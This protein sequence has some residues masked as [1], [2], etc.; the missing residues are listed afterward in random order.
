[1]SADLVQLQNDGLLALDFYSR[2]FTSPIKPFIRTDKI[3]NC[4][5]C[6]Y[7]LVAFEEQKRVSDNRKVKRIAQ[8][9]IFEYMCMSY[10]FNKF[11]NNQGFKADIP[12]W[13]KALYITSPSVQPYFS[14][15]YQTTKFINDNTALYDIDFSSFCDT[16][17]DALVLLGDQVTRKSPFQNIKG[18]DIKVTSG[19]TIYYSDSIRAIDK[20]I[21]LAG[22]ESISYGQIIG[23][24]GNPA[25]SGGGKVENG[26]DFVSK[27]YMFYVNKDFIKKILS[28]DILEPS[29]H[30]IL[31]NHLFNL[32]LSRKIYEKIWKNGEL[33]WNKED[34]KIVKQQKIIE[35]MK[36]S[37]A[38]DILVK[39]FLEITSKTYTAAD[40]NAKLGNEKFKTALNLVI[41]TVDAG[42]AE[43]TAVINEDGAVKES[44]KL[45]DKIRE[46]YTKNIKPSRD[47]VNNYLIGTR[48]TR[49]N[50][51]WQNFKLKPC[52]LDRTDQLCFGSIDTLMKDLPSSCKKKSFNHY[53]DKDKQDYPTLLFGQ[54]SFNSK[55]SSKSKVGK[56]IN[57]LETALDRMMVTGWSQQQQGQHSRYRRGKNAFK[58]FL[59]QTDTKTVNEFV[60]NFQQKRGIL[61]EQLTKQLR[62]GFISHIDENDVDKILQGAYDYYY[63]QQQGQQRIASRG[64]GGKCPSCIDRSRTTAIPTV[65]P[66]DVQDYLLTDWHQNDDPVLEVQCFLFILY[67]ITNLDDISWKNIDENSQIWNIISRVGDALVNKLNNE[68]L[69]FPVFTQADFPEVA[70]ASH[71]VNETF[72]KEEFDSI[73]NIIK[74]IP[75]I[76]YID[77][78]ELEEEEEGKV[79]STPG[80]KTNGDG[81]VPLTTPTTDAQMTPLPMTPTMATRITPQTVEA[82]R[83]VRIWKDSPEGKEKIAAKQAAKEY[84]N[85]NRDTVP[86]SL[87]DQLNLVESQGGGRRKKR[88]K[89]KNRRKKKKRTKRKK[90]K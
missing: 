13:L 29:K 70:H 67:Y 83:L 12:P 88:T 82:Q 66:E 69:T 45:K 17:N 52:G 79:S 15:K 5:P 90:R 39:Y 11:V 8:A 46:I 42:L 56:T 36:P 84:A 77:S 40:I 78:F 89:R 14:V 2:N 32:N 76:K 26:Q 81:I 58:K 31:F 18:V 72:P 28:P 57:S 20:F 51:K 61:E 41:T 9:K 62:T 4:S 7:S 33:L 16:T 53:I 44:K 30:D 24:K 43:C 50:K 35:H 87:L 71:N 63:D 73:N 65:P 3:P 49:N 22:D 75:E 64:G 68:K 34:E 23:K 10:I 60:E 59:K 55:K 54:V 48:Q 21:K 1:M 80:Q 38:M 25:S 85:A 74:S 6:F 86:V 27:I 47:K 37:D 19:D